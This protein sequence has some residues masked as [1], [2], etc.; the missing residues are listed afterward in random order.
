MA[1]TKQTARRVLDHMLPTAAAHA[2]AVLERRRPSIVKRSHVSALQVSQQWTTTRA[3]LDDL[4]RMLRHPVG[5]LDRAAFDRMTQTL[6]KYTETIEGLREASLRSPDDGDHEDLDRRKTAAGAPAEDDDVNQ[7][8]EGE[9]DCEENSE[10]N[11][12]EEGEEESD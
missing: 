9:A 4:A 1:R 11:S 12:E 5:D 8:A 7:D 10:E 3:A 6:R 2:A